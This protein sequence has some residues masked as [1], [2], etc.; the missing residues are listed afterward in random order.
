M[1]TKDP[2]TVFTIPY[3]EPVKWSPYPHTTFSTQFGKSH[4]CRKW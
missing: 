2:I 4:R 1:E 3:P